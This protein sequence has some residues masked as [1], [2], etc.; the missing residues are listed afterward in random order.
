MNP[1]MIN[2]NT[3]R[4][5]LIVTVVFFISATGPILSSEDAMN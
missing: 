2:E 4:D 3:N 1:P 5:E